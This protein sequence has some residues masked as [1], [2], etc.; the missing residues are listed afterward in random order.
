MGSPS[1][2][3]KGGASDAPEL[4]SPRGEP[5]T[6]LVDR[7][8]GHDT[9]QTAR[10]VLQNIDKVL[11]E[12]SAPLH[13]AITNF[14]TFSGALA[15]NSNRLDEIVDGLVRLT[16][17]STNQQQ[18]AVYDLEAPK[19]RAD[20]K[21]PHGQLVIPEPTAVVALDTQ[22]ILLRPREGAIV[23]F[24]GAQWS[25]AL[26][27]LV[28]SKIIQSFENANY[29]EAGRP[30]DASTANFQLLLDI[31][32]FQVSSSGDGAAE[33]ELSAKLMNNTGQFVAAK[34]FRSESPCS[35]TDALAAVKALNQAFGAVSTDVVLWTLQSLA[36]GSD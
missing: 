2:V 12:N 31:R 27:K 10:D 28:Q 22:R 11:A 4:G 33:V 29:L 24:E 26:P 18:L 14:D 3:L 34:V 16:G 15:R 25:D 7:R 1:I 32:T 13:S 19:F 9:M 17:G 35:A 36:A 6:L 23:A 21:V 8:A 30:S 20:I 5:P